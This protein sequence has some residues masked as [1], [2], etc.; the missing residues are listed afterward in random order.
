MSREVRFLFV[1]LSLLA[2]IDRFIPQVFMKDFDALVKFD[3]KSANFFDE[4]N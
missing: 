4:V 1:R 3:E 2:K